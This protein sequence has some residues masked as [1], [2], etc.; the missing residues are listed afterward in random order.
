MTNSL[1]NIKLLL[2][3][4]NLDSLA[5]VADKSKKR[6]EDLNLTIAVCHKVFFDAGNSCQRWTL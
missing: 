1:L 3:D 4:L 5:D 2:S 6:C